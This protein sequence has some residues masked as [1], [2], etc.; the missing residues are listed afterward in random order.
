MVCKYSLQLIGY[1]RGCQKELPLMQLSEGEDFPICLV[2]RFFLLGGRFEVNQC[3]F[4]ACPIAVA[5]NS[6]LAGMQPFWAAGGRFRKS[7]I[8]WINFLLAF[9]I[10]IIK[11][12]R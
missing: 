5:Y 1:Y 4:P 7:V 3:T 10:I 6:L 8:G 2:G 11:F 9:Y 12:S